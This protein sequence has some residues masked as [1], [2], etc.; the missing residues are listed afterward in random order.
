MIDEKH[1]L[2]SLKTF[3]FPRLSGTEFE[4]KS[5]NL[6]RKKIKNLNLNPK[7][8]EF[9][10]STFFS[11]IYPRL[12]LFL[13]FWLHL[14]LFLNIHILFTTIN[15]SLVLFLLLI[16]I[17]IT[18]N[19]EKIK[20]GRKLYSQNI[21]VKLPLRSNEKKETNIME[22]DKNRNILFFAHLDSKGQVFSVKFRVL[23]Y[24]I[25]LS[26]FSFGLLVNIINSYF[27]FN[28]IFLSYICGILFL[29][30][31]GI[32]TILV[33]LN[34]TNNKSKGAIDNASGISIVMELL[35]FY[36]NPLNRLQNYNIWFVFTGAEESGTM[37]VRNFYEYIKNFDRNN[38]YIINF[39]SVAKKVN[40]YDHGL[41]NNKNFK[42]YNYISENKDVMSIENVKRIYIGIYSDGLFLLKKKF[43]GI[44]NGDESSYNYIHSTND[45]IDKINPLILQRLCQFYI[46]LLNEIDSYSK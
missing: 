4:R 37:G 31:N 42:S 23:L 25:W 9:V 1:I 10:F 34:F 18:R 27:L 36:S 28:A 6:A 40:L 33:L 35:N 7:I 41:F 17:L 13:L 26:S 3:S 44:G 15:I 24:Y 38:T 45:D 43:Q 30:V 46:I 8:Q 2:E 22:R 14:I 11:R 19:P 20:L 39:D 16:L 32:A 21:F 29:H 5:F 12:S